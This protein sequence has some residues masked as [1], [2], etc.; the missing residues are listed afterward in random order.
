MLIGHFLELSIPTERPLDSL[1]FYRQLGFTIATDTGADVSAQAVVSDGRLSIALCDR[2]TAQPTLVFA[3]PGFSTRIDELERAGLIVDDVA[4]GEHTFNRLDGHIQN[5]PCLRLVEARTHSPVGQR[6]SLLGWFDEIS[7]A[8]QRA[9]VSALEALGFVALASDGVFGGGFTLTSDTITVSLYGRGESS[10]ACVHF[11]C[12]DVTSLRTALRSR[13]VDEDLALASHLD[14]DGYC[15]FRAP[16][17]TVLVV[18]Q[19]D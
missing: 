3:C 10:S 18:R 7:L 17:G 2:R 5:G 13:G 8:A 14:A 6:P 15:I 19:S 9:N 16:E 11:E 12:N 1:E 4:I